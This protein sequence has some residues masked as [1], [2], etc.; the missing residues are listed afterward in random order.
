MRF[1]KLLGDTAQSDRAKDFRKRH[2]RRSSAS[3]RISDGCK[4]NRKHMM[5]L[6]QKEFERI[7]REPGKHNLTSDRA[8]PLTVANCLHV[9]TVL[10]C[11]KHG[12]D[13]LYGLYQLV[14]SSTDGLTNSNHSQYGGSGSSDRNVDAGIAYRLA[15]IKVHPDKNHHPE[16]HKAF[17]IVQQAWNEVQ[18]LT[19]N[20]R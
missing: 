16:S 12:V 14:R 18:R 2:H 11:A 9:I 10:E 6:A 13:P 5:S 4:V 19:A 7:S 20:A 15:L 17:L 8:V 1:Q 3:Q